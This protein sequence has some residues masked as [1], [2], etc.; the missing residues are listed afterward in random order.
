MCSLNSTKLQGSCLLKCD[1]VVCGWLV[2]FVLEDHIDFIFWVKQLK[3]SSLTAWPWRWRHYDPLKHWYL[4]TSCHSVTCQKTW[5]CINTAVR[6]SHLAVCQ[7]LY[8]CHFGVQY[9]EPSFKVVCGCLSVT[10]L[11]YHMIVECE[12]EQNLRHAHECA[13][14]KAGGSCLYVCMVNEGFLSSDYVWSATDN[15]ETSFKST[16]LMKLLYLHVILFKVISFRSYT[17]LC[18]AF[19][20]LRHPLKSLH[21]SALRNSATSIHL[22]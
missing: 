5:I 19:Q 21:K 10:Q 11:T 16:S 7:A 9:Y 17:M 8:V 18:R 2:S 6:T 22:S 3:N 4:C 15:N 12:E 13:W 20:P 14:F 1:T